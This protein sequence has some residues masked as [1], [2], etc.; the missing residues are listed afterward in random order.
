MYFHLQLT[1]NLLLIR[2][3]SPLFDLNDGIL[4]LQFHGKPTVEDNSNYNKVH[5]F[6]SFNEEKE[7]EKHNSSLNLL[8]VVSF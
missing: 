1:L 2:E 7:K 3:D 8:E 4:V 5:P 6:R